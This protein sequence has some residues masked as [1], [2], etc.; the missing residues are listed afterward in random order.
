MPNAPVRRKVRDLAVEEARAPIR[1]LHDAGIGV[2]GMWPLTAPGMPPPGPDFLREARNLGDDT[3]IK[4]KTKK[5]EAIFRPGERLTELYK[6]A[7]REPG[8][9]INVAVRGGRFEPASF[10][11]GH[12]WGQHA[13]AYVTSATSRFV[14]S[15]PVDGPH[16]ADVFVLGKMPWREETAKG[17]NLV[18]ASGEI[19]MRVL[20]DLH[21]E[22]RE[23]W[24]VT[25]LVKFM[26]PDDSST[27]KAAWVHDCLPLLHQELRIVRPKFILC[28]GADASKHLL[29][30]KFTVTYM[31]GRV[32]PY[33]FPIH[34]RS[35]VPEQTHTA[36][37]MTVLH[38]AEVART[39]EKERILR[40]NL[41]RFAYL[42]SGTNFDIEE[43]NLDHR[44]C[45]SLEDAE[46]WAHEAE[47]ELADLPRPERLVAWDLEWQGQHPINP[48]SYVR[49]IQASWG[50]KKAI[51][52]VLRE[53]GGAV[54]FKDRDGKPAIKRLA[55]L[56]SEFCKGKR[57]V[58]HF[59]ISD[60]EWS[61]SLGLDMTT[62]CPIPLYAKD[63]VSAYDQLRAGRGWIDTAMLQ[64]AIEETAPLGL[65]MLAMRYTMAP[66]YDIVL[67]DWK[68]AYCQERGIKAE[69]LEGY[70]DCP[71]DVLV[72]YANYDAD[73]TRRIAIEL[74]PLLDG[75]YEGNDCWEPFWESMIIQRPLLTIHEN[76]IKVDKG[77]ID[78]LTAK[79]MT[80]KA[81]KEEEIKNWAGWPEFNVRSVQQVKEFLFGEQ[82]NGKLTEDG[83]IVRLRPAG[84][85][86][87][88]I[89]PIL[90]TSKPPRRWSDLVERG[91]LAGASPSTAKQTLGVLAQENLNKADQINMIR[92]YRFLDQVLKSVL[93]PPRLDEQ[94][95]WVEGDDGFLEYDAGLAAAIDHDGRVRT[96]LYPT[97][98][99]GRCKSRRPNLQNISSQ[100]DPDYVRLLGG[101][102]DE[103]GRWVGGE[104]THTLRSIF[105]PEPGYSIINADYTG[106]ELYIAA[107]MSGSKRMQDHCIRSALA[108]GHADYYDIHSNVAVTAFRLPCEP[109][110]AGLKS[111]GKQNFRTLAKNVMFGMMYG[112]SAKAIALQALEQG[113]RVT[114]QDAQDVING[115]FEIYPELVPYFAAC[116]NRP[117][118]PRWMR[119]CFGRL[120]RFPKTYDERLLAEMGRVALNFPEQNG[121]ASA[122]DRA[123]AYLDDE[124]RRQRVEKE[125][126]LLLT[127]HDSVMLEARNDLVPAAVNLLRWAM[128]DM[129]DI[130]P[131]DLDGV[132]RGDG[133]YHF[134]LEIEVCP[135]HWSEKL[136]EEDAL[137]LGIPAE[138]AS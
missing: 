77:R 22:N 56:L 34:P 24:Y 90:D 123:I 79:F 67:E 124:L 16:P 130:W 109:T 44:T 18:G 27:L 14:Q 23:N 87:L 105:I 73:V 58:G 71:D 39:P 132:A 126:R 137:T 20:D 110:K 128:V 102:K 134:G 45:Y 117:I 33:T 122:V 118:H 65:E 53:A 12:I 76:G 36:L 61:R 64:H 54:A 115:I 94:D 46:A 99:S 35:D 119:G 7:L 51:C 25:N 84:A 133:P 116:Q 69:A 78:D 81:K 93:R 91:M 62:H 50:E 97:A 43:N 63:G 8:F 121:V 47:A 113:V 40:S 28:L 86:S 107:L 38:P 92:D 49:T 89:T 98:D 135:Y 52:F 88:Y 82:L 42:I 10:V 48:G 17:R 131:T 29:G 100:R 55:A 13:D 19:L 15:V 41:G 37:V 85:Q 112:R 5:Q 95:H 60:L 57:T 111:I 66:R 3:E 120:R 72:P 68:K 9:S 138:L 6:R 26:P 83:K 96:H 2:G 59:L 129:V 101:K 70:G 108:E 74:L 31:A 75:D 11:P 127:V 103:K 136:T 106:A 21:V 32:V 80:W 1:A 114:V 104:Y 4:T 30:D 125:I